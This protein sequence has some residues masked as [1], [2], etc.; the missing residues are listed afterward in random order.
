MSHRTLLLLVLLYPAFSVCQNYCYSTDKRPYLLFGTK[1]AYNYTHGN[2]NQDT[3]P[4]SYHK[5]AEMI[6]KVLTFYFSGCTP[7]QLW[8][9]NRHGTRYPD[10]AEIEAFSNLG[11][12]LKQV[13]ANYEQEK[14]SLCKEDF[15]LLK[16]WK[17]DTNIAET[18]AKD[19]TEQGFEDLSGIAK[20]QKEKF[21][22]LFEIPY[23]KKSYYV[24]YYYY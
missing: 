13:V 18:V 21:S 19:L 8:S 3:V 23:E 12:L 9:F 1:T 20:R 14:T 24:S 4:Q 17:W 15:N 10:D 22:D 16:T 11:S 6:K 5:I 7:L 2:L